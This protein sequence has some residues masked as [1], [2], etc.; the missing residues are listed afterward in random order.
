MSLPV[1]TQ[2]EL[3]DLFIST[4][5]S[6]APELTDTL[7]GSIID[8][9]AGTFSLA[10]TELTRLLIDQF[11]KTFLEL[12]NGP[13]ITGGPDDLQ[14]LAV[15]HFGTDFSR[16]QASLA[17]DTATFSRP[18]AAAGE[19][20]IPTGTIVK[21]LVDANGVSQRYETLAPLV[22]TNT[23]DASDLSGNIPIR[24]LVA[25][26]TG[27]AV[28]DTIIV[29][30][31]SLLDNTIVVTNIGN[32][33]GEDAETDA[34]YRQ[35][36]RNLVQ[37]LAGA[38]AVA[39]AAKA[40]TVSGIK[41]ATAIEKIKT[42]IE[43]DPTTNLT[44][45]AYFRM[46]VPTLYVADASGSASTALLNLVRSAIN[47]VK[48]LGVLISVE[49]ATPINVNWIAGITLNP[50][51]PNYATLVSDPQKL[52]DS[53]TDYINNIPVGTGFVRANAEAAI[54][55]IWGPSGTTDLTIFSTTTPVGDIAAAS[56]QKMIAGSVDLI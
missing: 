12:A 33:S 18:T 51:G 52:L 1:K 8:S 10:G 44:V 53:M 36:I 46:P 39:V 35:T 56:I 4:L 5:Q 27:N 34:T 42:V 48:A 50:S 28:L 17:L 11:N 37:A 21:T 31:S 38:T 16:P 41:N 20:I 24:A 26:S 6:V 47:Q 49:S 25:G 23:L 2:Q 22:L 45:G 13:E 9:L 7:D 15:D 14:T 30:E 3:Y 29:I 55:A 32:A 54:L 43:F 19:V 40:K